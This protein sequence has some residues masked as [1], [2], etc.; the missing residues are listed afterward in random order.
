MSEIKRTLG[1]RIQHEIIF[2]ILYFIGTAIAISCRI[3]VIGY[4]NV[5]K[6]IAD[7]KGGLILPWHGVTLLPIYV[8]RHLGLYAIVST[9]KDGD[10]QNRTLIKR[11]FKTIRGSTARQGVRALLETVRK[12]QDGKV[13]AFTPDGPKG[14][15]KKVQPGTI[16]MAKKTG[17][18]II[19][20][21][22]ACKPCKRL[23]SWDG[24]MVPMP[25]AKAVIVFSD[26]FYISEDTEDEEV[27]KI[28]EDAINESDKKAEEII[29]G[30]GKRL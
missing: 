1:E 7:N 10:L 3:K 2:R 4:D 23:S 9:S 25:F 29:S 27:A 19:T 18:P 13:V 30:V 11:G 24:H 6:M 28:I 21:G 14:P 12:I 8:L 5:K 17:C 20:V 22:V 16:M 15:N 26:P